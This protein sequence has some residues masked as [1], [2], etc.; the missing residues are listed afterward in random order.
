MTQLLDAPD[1]TASP[2]AAAARFTA[3]LKADSLSAATLD[4]TK[5]AILDLLGIMIG[6]KFG[7]ESTPA[8]DQAVAVL[9]APGNGRA[10]GHAQGY[11]PHYAAL[12]NGIYAHSLDFDDTHE[13]GSIHPGAPI[14]P[15][16]I[17]MGEEARA[18]G[19]RVLAAIVAAYDV[20]VRLSQAMNP[21]AVY[22]RGLH[23]TA[24]FG[25][26]GAA[27]GIGNL[28]GDDAALIESVLGLAGSITMGGQ[29]FLDT[30]GW[31]KRVQV[32]YAAHNAIVAYRFAAAGVPGSPKAFEGKYGA[33]VNFSGNPNPA[34]LEL[35]A[36]DSHAIDETAT[37]PYP[38]CRYAH[39]PLDA[40]IELLVENDLQ[41]A[42]IEHIDVRIPSVPIE[43]IAEP[44]A[45]KRDPRTMVDGQFSMYFVAAAA[46]LRRRFGL[47]DYD[48][49]G[50][51]EVQR[52]IERI[53]VTADAGLDRDAG[54]MAGA[55]V[56]RGRGQTWTRRIDVPSGEPE[57]ALD[58]DALTAKFDGLASV[59][60]DAARRAKIVDCV[61]RLDELQDIREFTNL[62]GPR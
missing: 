9:A 31:N 42:E 50:T 3:G 54:R 4:R 57:R 32:G 48:L 27:A 46:T 49:L 62:L 44:Q 55:V 53:D 43:L 13:N 22:S 16:I 33:F 47:A 41:P 15:A 59:G 7:A 21:T 1:L 29:Q 11:A 25:T 8:I 39:A 56:L 2:T 20:T 60:Y 19:R 10:V 26:F 18:G 23:P 24:V 12:L 14:I 51:P 36:G 58:W 38:C 35:L 30:G 37:K 6:A 52:L 5:Q 45:R 40:L 61:R 34:A 17:A 28:N